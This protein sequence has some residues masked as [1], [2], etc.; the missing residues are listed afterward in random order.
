MKVFCSL[1]I[2]SVRFD[3]S[4]FEQE[5]TRNCIGEIYLF[6]K[7]NLQAT[8]VRF[9]VPINVEKQFVANFLLCIIFAYF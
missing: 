3:K 4:Y 8:T 2:F 9:F 7:I 6:F 5:I 1:K